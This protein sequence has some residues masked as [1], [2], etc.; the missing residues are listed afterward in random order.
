V[1]PIRKSF[2]VQRQAYPLR[3][4]LKIAEKPGFKPHWGGKSSNKHD[5]YHFPMAHLILI[6]VDKG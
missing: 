2:D 6:I 5:K 1:H 4:T 3:Y